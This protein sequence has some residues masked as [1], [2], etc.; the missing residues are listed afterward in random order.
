MSDAS[1]GAALRGAVDLSSLR[2]RPQDQPPQGGSAPAGAGG[3]VIDVTDQTFEQLMQLSTQVPVVIHFRTDRSA[4]CGELD[5]VLE[6]VVREHGG[7][8]VLARVD[9]DRNPQIVQA[10]Q[11]P[12]APMVVALVGQRPVPMMNSAAP[13][14]Q[15]RQVFDQLLQLAQ[16]AGV[17]GSVDVSEDDA[18]PE[19]EEQPLPPLHQAAFDAIARED[20]DAAIAAYEKALTENPRDDEARAG[21]G[22]VRL[23][24]RVQGVDLDAVRRAAAE[25]PA[26]VDAQ[27]AV[28]DADMA[29][30][31][32]DDAFSRLLD[33]FQTS[34][35]D[36][37]PRVQE[38]LVELFGV[39]GAA[40]P[41]VVSARG[42]LASLLF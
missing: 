27:L 25:S 30:G 3:V 10:F 38:R 28:A 36:D 31:H 4:A 41:R 17:T 21:L 37:R 34:S 39:V 24:R 26:D 20:Y 33:L 5:P 23:L 35:P 9:V 22:Q 15:V 14:E 12:Q 16:Q 40:D 19:P 11:V 2:N 8:L 29:G 42:R 1:L 32:V 18:A 6:K 7:R 13:E